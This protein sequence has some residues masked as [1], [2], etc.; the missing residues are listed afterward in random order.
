MVLAIQEKNNG[1]IKDAIRY[2]NNKSIEDYI[3]LQT[4]KVVMDQMKH[5]PII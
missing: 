4:C 3:Q 1:Q 5:E 2:V